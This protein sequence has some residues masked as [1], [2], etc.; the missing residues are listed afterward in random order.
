MLSGR[1]RLVIAT[2]SLDTTLV[3]EM[4]GLCGVI[5]TRRLAG[6]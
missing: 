2:T 3:V 4:G 5:V 1:L 6:F